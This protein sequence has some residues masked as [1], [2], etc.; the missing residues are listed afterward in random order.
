MPLTRIIGLM[1]VQDT[2]RCCTE[3][4]SYIYREL[5]GLVLG[6]RFGA[7]QCWFGCVILNR[8]ANNYKMESAATA[9]TL[10]SFRSRRRVQKLSKSTPA[11][12]SLRDFSRGSL[13]SILLTIPRRRS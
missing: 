9:K 7:C 5:E 10:P 3:V 11:T 2:E 13:A 1:S 8:A 6:C 4:G 12:E